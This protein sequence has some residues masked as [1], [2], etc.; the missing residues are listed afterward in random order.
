MYVYIKRAPTTITLRV[1]RKRARGAR[2]FYGIVITSDD[3]S[4]LNRPAETLT[5]SDC[6]LKNAMEYGTKEIVCS[7]RGQRENVHVRRE[8]K[9]ERRRVENIR[10]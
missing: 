2:C 1:G 7:S 8:N 3:K 5:R 6:L 9:T 4:K 10:R